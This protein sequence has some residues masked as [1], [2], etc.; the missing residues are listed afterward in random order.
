MMELTLAGFDTETAGPDPLTDSIVSASVG[1]GSVAGWYPQTWLL[2]QSEPIPARATEIHGIT[3]EQ[4][5]REG[6]DPKVALPQ[7]RDALYQAWASG[8]AVV[9]YNIVFDFTM[10][11]R[12]LRRHGFAD[13]FQNRG[14]VIDPYVFDKAID[15]WRKGS[16]QLSDVAAHY[17]VQFDKDQA[18]GAEADAHTTAMLVAE[19][20]NNHKPEAPEGTADYMHWLH[21]WQRDHYKEQRIGF[22]DWR[23]RKG[24]PLPEPVNTDWPIQPA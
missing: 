14:P 8:S 20:F 11:D 18:H 19:L 16:R 21:L 23:R 3:T 9:G 4:A 2:K 12:N 15:R 6:T 22:A 7:I 24:D 17:G 5:N 10:L 13:G 1:I